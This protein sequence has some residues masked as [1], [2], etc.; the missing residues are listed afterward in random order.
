M[1]FSQFVAVAILPHAILPVLIVSIFR[2]VKAFGEAIVRE[3][4]EV[5]LISS[6]SLKEGLLDAANESGTDGLE[7]S[8]D[9]LV[10]LPAWL[11]HRLVSQALNQGFHLSHIAR[12]NGCQQM[13]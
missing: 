4:I 10:K 12:P 1:L 9:V 8:L 13:R 3:A 5:V 11:L 2:V 6:V 7:G